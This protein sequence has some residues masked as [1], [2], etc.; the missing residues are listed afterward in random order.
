MCGL[1]I[2]TAP[3][4]RTE[5]N[6]EQ[7]FSKYFLNE[8]NQWMNGRDLAP[9]SATDAH[10]LLIF[11]ST[12]CHLLGLYHW[13]KRFWKK[14]ILLGRAP[15]WKESTSLETCHFPVST[16]ASGGCLF[17][18]DVFLG[19]VWSPPV[20]SLPRS[21]L[22]WIQSFSSPYLTSLLPGWGS[23][24]ISRQQTCH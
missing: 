2:D 12:Q 21:E 4:S 20:V 17:E 13:A 10:W 16:H 1:I 14:S 15:R 3:P 24:L 6:T 19:K 8:L 7:D 11:F 22:H 9:L 18:R 23:C 5:P